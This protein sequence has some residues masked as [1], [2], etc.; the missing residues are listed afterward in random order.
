MMM[1]M[2]CNKL[3]FL[4]LPLILSNWH[5]VGI[6]PVLAD[7]GINLVDGPGKTGGPELFDNDVFASHL[8]TLGDQIALADDTG[9][10]NL[11]FLPKSIDFR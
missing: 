9:T 11:V 7:E 6:G 10:V 8:P 4:I 5:L 2:K 1:M 3:I